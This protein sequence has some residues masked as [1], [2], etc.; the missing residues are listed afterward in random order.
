MGMVGLT[1]VPAGA[2]SLNTYTYN[3]DGQLSIFEND[4]CTPSPCTET[5]TFSFRFAWIGDPTPPLFYLGEIV[6]GSATVTSFGPLSPFEMFEGPL[7]NF[8]FYLPFGN[9]GD[10]IDVVTSPIVT[11]TPWIA[12]I[13]SSPN[14][15]ACGTPSCFTDF[16]PPDGNTIALPFSFQVTVTAVPEEGTLGLLSFGL[17][18][19]A[20]W[21]WK[22]RGRALA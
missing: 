8:V 5:L 9:T 1:A 12:P 13:F 10:E 2:V 18:G 21:Q 11:D 15:Y 16:S 6:L 4:V 3:V 7:T 14:L 19:L 20:L 17:V 22:Q